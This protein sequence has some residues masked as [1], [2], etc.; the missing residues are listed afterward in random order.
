MERNDTHAIKLNKRWRAN[1]YH[2][3]IPFIVLTMKRDFIKDPL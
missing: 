1:K 3:T 2:K